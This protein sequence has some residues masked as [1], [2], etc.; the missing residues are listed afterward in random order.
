MDSDRRCFPPHISEI[1][2]CAVLPWLSHCSQDWL[3]KSLSSTLKIQPTWVASLVFSVQWAVI[4][5]LIRRWQT[6]VAPESHIIS[7][8]SMHAYSHKFSTD[9]QNFGNMGFV[10]WY[11]QVLVYF[12]LPLRSRRVNNAWYCSPVPSLCYLCVIC[13]DFV[14]S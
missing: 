10:W 7:Y 14:Q 5:H 1:V 8:L 12:W 11:T 4:P 13:K 3:Y 6:A 9:V 2:S